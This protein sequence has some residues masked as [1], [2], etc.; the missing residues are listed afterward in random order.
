MSQQNVEVVQ[1]VFD[2]VARRDTAAVLALYDPKVEWDT[3]R[4]SLGELLGGTVYHG[5]EGLRSLFHQLHEPWESYE[6]HLEELIDAGGE[7]VITVVTT[8]GRGRATGIEVEQRHQAAV[9]TIRNQKVARVVWFSTRAEAL[10]ATGLA[11]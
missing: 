7:E 11:E 5:H 3:S 10:E 8:R 6:D 1:R 4:G 9:W 2:A